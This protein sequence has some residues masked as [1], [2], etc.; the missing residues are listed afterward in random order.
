MTND[1]TVTT[2]NVLLN[3]IEGD[4][5]RIT[6]TV[7]IS[8]VT[9][10]VGTGDP[11]TGPGPT[12]RVLLKGTVKVALKIT[13]PPLLVPF[14]TNSKIKIVTSRLF[15]IPYCPVEVNKIEIGDIL[16]AFY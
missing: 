10:V 8:K 1:L 3:K 5:Y 14:C 6:K 11:A 16:F 12:A 13:F 4:I 15:L 2:V 9:T 7:S